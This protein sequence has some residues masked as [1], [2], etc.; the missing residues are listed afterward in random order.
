MLFSGITPLAA[1]PTRYMCHTHILPRVVSPNPPLMM[2]AWRATHSVNVDGL[3][4]GDLGLLG[5][6]EGGLGGGANGGLGGGLEAKGRG[7]GGQDAEGGG[8]LHGCFDW[9]IQAEN[10]ECH[11]NLS[12][13]EDTR[14]L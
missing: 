9:R 8:E 12:I 5:G 2:H 3:D 14:V 7:A 6:H 11:E 10:G 1:T 13:F 4:H